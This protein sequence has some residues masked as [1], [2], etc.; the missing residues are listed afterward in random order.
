M[1]LHIRRHRIDIDFVYNRRHYEIGQ[2]QRQTSPVAE[3]IK[4][5]EDIT[6]T[7]SLD[8]LRQKLA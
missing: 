8:A 7:I 5:V 3:H 4:F 2:E 1:I 6:D